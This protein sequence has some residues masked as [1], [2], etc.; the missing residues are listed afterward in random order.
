MV[1]YLKA[2]LKLL[3]CSTHLSHTLTASLKYTI[4]KALILITKTRL[5][6][7]IEKVTTKN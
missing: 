1:R 5:F 3:F 6:K 4:R 7:Y 2:K